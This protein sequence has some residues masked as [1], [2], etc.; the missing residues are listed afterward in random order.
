MHLLVKAVER[1]LVIQDGLLVELDQ[2]VDILADGVRQDQLASQAVALVELATEAR[3]LSHDFNEIALS[4]SILVLNLL[5]LLQLLGESLLQGSVFL[6]RMRQLYLVFLYDP[7]SN[8]LVY[9]LAR[10]A[11]ILLHKTDGLCLIAQLSR[12]GL[13]VELLE[14]HVCRFVGRIRTQSSFAVFK[15]LVWRLL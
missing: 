8:L 10:L 15:A 7:A 13:A 3:Q 1:E 11:Q 4:F 9:G 2:L 14:D 6:E 12:W 5:F